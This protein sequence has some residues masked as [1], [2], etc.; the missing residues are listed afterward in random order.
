M[1][2]ILPRSQP[3]RR[4]PAG[5]GPTLTA[6]LA[7]STPPT[8]LAI[9]TPATSGARR[10]GAR[11]SQGAEPVPGRAGRVGFAGCPGA[12]TAA[13][14]VTIGRHD[15]RAG[16]VG[17]AG[18][19]RRAGR[20][21]RVR[22]DRPDDRGRRGHG[23]PRASGDGVVGWAQVR[24]ARDAGR[25]QAARRPGGR[26]RALGVRRTRPARG[27]ARPWRALAAARRRDRGLPVRARA[28]QRRRDLGRR[29][30]RLCRARAR[31]TPAPDRPGHR[32]AAGQRPRGARRDRQPR[33]RR[34]GP[35]VARR[36]GERGGVR[37]A[38]STD[39]AR[40]HPQ[41][42]LGGDRRRRVRRA[43]ARWHLVLAG[44]RRPRRRSRGDRDAAGWHPG[45][46]RGSWPAA[47]LDGR[48]ANLAG[49]HEQPGARSTCGRSSGSAAEC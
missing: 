33:R 38:P 4:G 9:C 18:I 6:W 39:R 22:G 46:G 12:W 10:V 35:A 32:R 19:R 43:L 29:R 5:S 13:L 37:D 31:R 23:E 20:R 15:R 25:P 47:A 16:A 21:R 1:Y 11:Y 17:A 42:D 7:A 27:L 14:G 40:G 48:R 41:G 8:S 44:Q 36:R 34:P 45:G 26:R 24:G 30:P 3:R 28:G 2:A 49:H